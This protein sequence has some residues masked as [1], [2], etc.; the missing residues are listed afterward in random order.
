[1]HTP[2]LNFPFLDGDVPR[3]NSNG[4]RVSGHVT[5]MHVIKILTAQ[6]LR[7]T[8]SKFYR[9]HYELVSKFEVGLN[10]LSQQGL[11]EFHGDLV[12]KSRKII[13]SAQCRNRVRSI[14][15]IPF[16]IMSQNLVKI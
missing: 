13:S 11:S 14:T 5:T 12:Y 4:F 10:S 16:E 8:I 3:S 15:L 2:V 7:N 1:M 6:L 9:R